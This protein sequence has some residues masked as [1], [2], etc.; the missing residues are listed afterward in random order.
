MQHRLLP[1][2]GQA[3]QGPR[4]PAQWAG[5]SSSAAQQH[6]APAGPVGRQEGHEQHHLGAGR[7]GGLT[8]LSHSGQAYLRT[9]CCVG[10]W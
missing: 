6:L 3:P 2:T 4:Q 8:L 10:G 7:G 9:Y 1:G 5:G